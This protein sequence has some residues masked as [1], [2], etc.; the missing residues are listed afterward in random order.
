MWDDWRAREMPN[1]IQD[2]LQNTVVLV[3]SQLAEFKRS[4]SPPP[5]A[6]II[7]SFVYCVSEFVTSA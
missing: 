3:L 6:N 4:E 5:T 7:P 2:I 1:E